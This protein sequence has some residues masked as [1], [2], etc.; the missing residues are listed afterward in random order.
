MQTITQGYERSIYQGFEACVLSGAMNDAALGQFV[1]TTITGVHALA[2]LP[3]TLLSTAENIET[4]QPRA[5]NRTSAAEANA[6]ANVIRR[7]RQTGGATLA[8]QTYDWLIDQGTAQKRAD[9][10]STFTARGYK[11]TSVSGALA[12]LKKN[13]RALSANGLWE[14]VRQPAQTATAPTR[15]SA[16]IAQETGQAELRTGTTG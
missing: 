13:G 9:I 6:S 11:T 12:E 16:A 3:A 15:K 8:N 4:P 1:R 14:A 5:R 10:I 2:A 7:G